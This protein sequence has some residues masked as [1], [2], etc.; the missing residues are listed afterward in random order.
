MATQSVKKSQKQMTKMTKEEMLAKAYK[1][2]KDA[3]I[4]HPFYTGKIE[5]SPKCCVRDFDDFAIWYTPGV[6]EV[7]K[8][9]HKNPS[10]VYEHTNKGNMV[11]VVSDGTRVLGL[12]DIGPEAGLPV[13]EGKG[14]LFK[15]FFLFLK[16][17]FISYAHYT[18]LNLLKQRL[19]FM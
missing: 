2:A 3:M 8:D 16:F 5:V 10:Q 19:I 9:I 17:V 11:A 15:Y 6:A 13:M 4:L 14:L 12:G 1:P 18:Q 7:C